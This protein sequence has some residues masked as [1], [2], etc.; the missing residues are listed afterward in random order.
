MHSVIG[1]QVL[2]NYFD[3]VDIFANNSHFTK[4]SQNHIRIHTVSKQTWASVFGFGEAILGRFCADL[5]L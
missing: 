1:I 4:G 2:F 5:F 3:S